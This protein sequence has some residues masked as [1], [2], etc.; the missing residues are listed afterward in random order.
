MGTLTAALVPLILSLTALAGLVRGVDVYKALLTGAEEGLGILIR[1]LPNLI[2][3]MTAI[4]MVR[5]SGF[6]DW[7][8]EG[9]APVLT[10]V[11]IPPQLV[12]LLL[13]RPLSGSGALGVG[14]ELMRTYGP[15]SLI[16]RTA[17][18][19]LGS[20]ETTFYTIGVYFAAAGVEKTRYAVPAALIADLAGFLAAAWAVR[21][22][23]P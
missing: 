4:A 7:A 14:A 23:F 1:I 18:V 22:F 19:M 5:S 9:L 6:L 8:A 2:C 16:G 3:L 15:D 21:V 17:A 10:R 12:A 20:T 11:G 13:I